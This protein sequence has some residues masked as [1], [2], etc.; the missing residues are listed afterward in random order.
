MRLRVSILLFC[1]DRSPS[2]KLYF[3]YL[4]VHARSGGLCW[5]PTG[6]L[7]TCTCDNHT[8]SLSSLGTTKVWLEG[9][10]LNLNHKN[11]TM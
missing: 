9:L 5:F 3:S 10:K 11:Q 8:L 1:G 4:C 7:V 6:N 2:V